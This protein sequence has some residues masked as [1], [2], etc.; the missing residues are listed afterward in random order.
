MKLPMFVAIDVIEPQ[1]GGD[2]SLELCGNLIR[3][4]PT[5]RRI[6]EYPHARPRHITAKPAGLVDKIRQ[7]RRRRHRVSVG[8][9]DVQ[10]HSQGT[11]PPRPIDGVG[12]GWSPNHETGRCQDSVA[13]SRLNRRVDF[14]RKTEIV[15]RYDQRLQCAAPRRSRRK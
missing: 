1:S 3:D 14:G 7:T 6:E 5:H 13:V 11:H 10:S 8:E 12:G 4:L 2:K 9:N 15:G